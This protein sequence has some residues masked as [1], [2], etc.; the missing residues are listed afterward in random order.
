MVAAGSL[1]G[2]MEPGFVLFCFVWFGSVGTLCLIAVG[3]LG[4]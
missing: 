1:A 2:S 4:L 3:Y